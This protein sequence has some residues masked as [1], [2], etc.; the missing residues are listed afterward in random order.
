MCSSDLEVLDD[1][2]GV[3]PEQL[4]RLGDRFYRPPGETEPGSGLGLSIVRRI[5]DWHGL[6]VDWGPREDAPG[7]RVGLRR[8]GAPA[9]ATTEAGAA[10]ETA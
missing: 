2:P 1:G 7:F 10:V 5:A 8:A 9:A 6:A 4:G 3:A